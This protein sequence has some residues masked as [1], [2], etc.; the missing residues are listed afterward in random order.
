MVTVNGA[1]FRP[2]PRGMPAPLPPTPEPGL[3]GR[4]SGAQRHSG[5]QPV[6]LPRNRV[7]G[8]PAA[9]G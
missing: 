4:L 9:S 3:C 6:P 8:A 2:S 7:E 1:G 5:A